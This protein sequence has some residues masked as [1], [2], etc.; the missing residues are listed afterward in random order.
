MLGLSHEIEKALVLFLG[1]NGAAEFFQRHGN[2]CDVCRITVALRI[3]FDSINRIEES[4]EILDNRQCD[5]G[6]S[7]A[8]F[9]KFRLIGSTLHINR[10]VR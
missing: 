4:R 8:W 3:D 6:R 9:S 2:K 10:A 1:L 5:I 7:R